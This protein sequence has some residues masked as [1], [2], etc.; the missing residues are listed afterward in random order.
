MAG[1]KPFFSV[2]IPT[3]NEERYLPKLLGNLAG[4][5]DRDFEVIVIDGHS[6]DRTIERARGFKGGIKRLRILAAERANV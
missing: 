1:G 5:I 6:K 3:L 4:Q 2:V